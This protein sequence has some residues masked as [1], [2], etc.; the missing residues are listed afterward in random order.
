MQKTQSITKN[1]N[2]AVF[3]ARW[4]SVLVVARLSVLSRLSRSCVLFYTNVRCVCVL[5][6]LK[7]ILR[8]SLLAFMGSVDRCKCSLH[9]LAACV[10]MQCLAHARALCLP[11]LLWRRRPVKRF[12]LV[13]CA[14]LFIGCLCE[15]M[16]AMRVRLNE[17][18]LVCLSCDVPVVLL[19]AFGARSVA[20][21]SRSRAFDRGTTP[22]A[23]A[24][25]TR[26][27]RSTS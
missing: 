11:A 12:V 3:F 23:A 25:A 10:C 16:V 14:L 1:N 2:D 20:D 18:A 4:G 27:R 17:C 22:R 26:R 5:C 8:L 24:R 7:R 13:H 19:Q 21:F 9:P 15:R 6:A